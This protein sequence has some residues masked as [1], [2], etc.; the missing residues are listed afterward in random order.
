MDEW[1][2]Y[3]WWVPHLCGG[4]SPNNSH[5]IEQLQSHYCATKQ[6]DCTRCPGLT[7][8]TMGMPFEPFA[9]HLMS[10]CK[11]NRS[12]LLCPGIITQRMYARN[13]MVILLQLCKILTTVKKV[14]VSAESFPESLIRKCKSMMQICKLASLT[15]AMKNHVKWSFEINWSIMWS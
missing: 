2:I 10:D 11:D 14:S 6:Q 5:W 9:T 1:V 3:S 8:C 13:K 7:Q 12:R 4:I 15:E